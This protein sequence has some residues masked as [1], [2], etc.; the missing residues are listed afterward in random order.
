MVLELM[1]LVGVVGDLV[2]V[3][4]SNAAAVVHFVD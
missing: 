4:F 3:V 2:I 1:E